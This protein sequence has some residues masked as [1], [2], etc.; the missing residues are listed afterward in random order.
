MILDRR[1]LVTELL[2]QNPMVVIFVLP[3]ACTGLDDFPA[4]RPLRLNIGRQLVP[5][6]CIQVGEY[7]LRFSA[8]FNRVPRSLVIPWSALLFAGTE[9]HLAELAAR[10]KAASQPSTPQATSDSNVVHVDFRA[11]RRRDDG[12]A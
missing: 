11:R 4:N 9:A 1:Q 6:M 7:A 8:S 5:D 3:G 10:A 2:A 12:A